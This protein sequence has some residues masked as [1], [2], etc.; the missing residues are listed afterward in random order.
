MAPAASA[1][2]TEMARIGVPLPHLEST[3]CCYMDY[4]ATTPIFPEVGS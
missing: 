3:G 2:D 4:N 1:A